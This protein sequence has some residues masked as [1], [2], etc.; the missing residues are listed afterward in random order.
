MSRLTINE[1]MKLKLE[2]FL[3]RLKGYDFD[4]VSRFESKVTYAFF[5]S[6][7]FELVDSHFILLEL[8]ARENEQEMIVLLKLFD[9]YLKSFTDAYYNSEE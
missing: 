2:V 7:E 9:E 3:L 8:I 6:K 4:L 1:L 5:V